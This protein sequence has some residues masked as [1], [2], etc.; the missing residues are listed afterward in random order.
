MARQAVVE[1]TAMTGSLVLALLSLLATLVYLALFVAW[2]LL[3]TG[4]SPIRNAVSDYAVGGYGRLFRYGLWA[5]S[6]GVLALAFALLVNVKSPPL[7]ARDLIYLLLIPVAR[8][9]MSLFPTDVEGRRLSRTGLL[10]YVFAI[11]A[12]TF[13]YLVISETTP[14]LRNLEPAPWLSTS[15]RVVA[16]AVA[17]EL[18]LVVVTMLRP[19]RRRVFGLFERLFLLT[20]NVWFLLVAGLLIARAT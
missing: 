7:A 18:A 16:W 5:S 19:L 10:H 2:H 15:L 6:V 14:V 8:V 17:P 3:P 1:G 20:T 4:Y 9:G 13:T 12:F 11:A